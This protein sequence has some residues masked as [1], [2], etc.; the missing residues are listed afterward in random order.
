MKE[1]W[2]YVIIAILAMTLSSITG[3]AQNPIVQ[4]CYTADPAPMV[5][6]DRFYIYID[7][8]EGPDYYNMNEWRV[9]SSADMV[10]WTDH[11]AQLPLTAFS[12]AKAGTAW[13]AQCI[14]RYSKFYWYVCCTDT[15]SNINA[16]G[17]AVSDSPTGPFKDALG[18]PMISGGWGY[19]DPTVF[20][21]DDGQAYIYWGNPGL[22]C[23]KVNEDMISY[24]GDIVE[25]EQTVE[26]FGG[27]KEP[28]EGVQYKDLYEEGPWF[29]KRGGKYYLLYAAG[30]V[31]EHIS[32]SMSD[33]PTGPWKYMGKIMPL[34]DTNSFT[35]H[36][37][38]VDFKG[39]SY[40][41][42]HTGWLPG[43]GGFT[44]SVCIEEFKYNED[45]TIP[46]IMAT[47]E[48]VAP[49][50]TL[51]PYLKTEA[52]TM[53]WGLGLKT[54]Q[55][56]NTGV[57]VTSI[58]NGGRLKVREVD[59]GNIGAG[60]FTASV[61]S[62]SKGGMVELRLDMPDGELIGT[63]SVSYTGGWTQWKEESTNIIGSVTGKHDLW[64]VFK[65]DGAEELF[66]MDYWQFAEKEQNK[67]LVALNASID[68]FKIDILSG[69][70]HTA[71][72]KVMAIYTD[73]TATDV[74]DEAEIRAVTPGVVS[75]N[76][77]VVTGVA[78]GKTDIEVSYGGK[79]SILKL[80][81]R[82]IEKEYTVDRLSFEAFGK[83][84]NE[85][86]LLSRSQLS[87]SLFAIYQDGH[88]EE[89][90]QVADVD[91]QN[92]EVLLVEAGQIMALKDG[93]STVTFSYKST[94][95]E[96][97]SVT[98]HIVSS[99]FPLTAQ[100]FNPNIYSEGSFDETTHTLV[101]GQYGFGGWWYDDGVD[102]SEYKYLVVKLGNTESCGAS[103]NIFDENSYWSKP[104]AYVVGGKRQMVVNLNDAYKKQDDGSSVKLNPSHIYG[105]GFWSLGGSPIVI[106][107]VYLTNSD[108]YEDPTG[109]VDVV[110]DKD[111]L[112]DV[113]TITGIKLRT[114]VRRSEVIRE[115]PVGIYIVGREKIAILK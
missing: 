69:N 100:L 78:Y 68:Q 22:F 36:C 84:V 43:G 16:I 94:F 90:T 45:G 74:T 29:Y 98:V 54:G 24:S 56:S 65:G 51:N 55:D 25:V 15:E 111:P 105:V 44:R 50:G 14:E 85:L 17:V 6:G 47:K 66:N 8:D 34:Q 86:K 19:I 37:G 21:D 109:I 95:G 97:Q 76:G 28:K 9:Y 101:T 49:V 81:V 12:W 18:K 38:V 72:I 77:G 87:Y 93:E 108:D 48:G 96:R 35:N 32:Y 20:I 62:G 27:P 1:N 106:D 92:P 59:F 112:V 115:L 91:I 2:K 114:Q 103:F 10:N 31:P 30:G 64:F 40:F 113:Y 57:Y 46:T 61:A 5:Y 71:N 88:T 110:V 89:I 52:E 33:S 73:G 107:K 60:I 104:A 11:G 42:Y 39:K 53:A 70:V 7:R 82:D 63:L 80:I 67:S 23:V 58:R 41:A 102:L 83:Q 13:A 79:S 3:Y 75:V 99:T 4:T 26:G